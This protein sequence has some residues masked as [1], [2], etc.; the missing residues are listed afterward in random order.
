MTENVKHVEVL[1]EMLANA[2]VLGLHPYECEA[3]K[4]ARERLQREAAGDGEG[5]G[6]DLRLFDS[7][8][9]N[10]VNHANCYRDM[11]KED[12]IAA[13]VKLTE[14]AM[15]ANVRDAKWPAPHTTPASAEPDCGTCDGTGR[16]GGDGS[17]MPCNDCGGSG[18]IEQSHPTPAA[19][20]AECTHTSSHAAPWRCAKCGH[21]FDAAR[22]T[23][24]A[25]GNG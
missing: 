10:V 6:V 1:G 11:D 25:N 17:P 18:R 16:E 22:A 24:G 21:R 13:A 15:A 4:A 19:L 12:A 2:N 20:D 8:W 14:Q 7:Q 5:D 3:I 9:V 23:T